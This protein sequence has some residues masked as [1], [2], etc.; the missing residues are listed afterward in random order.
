[1]NGLGLGANIQ[2]K[3][4]EKRNKI[5]NLTLGVNRKV[6][7]YKIDQ[8]RD[9]SSLFSRSQALSWLKMDFSSINYKIE[10]YDVKW[11]NS[12]NLTYLDYLKYVYAVLADNYQNEYVFKNEFLNNWL[13]KELG[14]TNS[15][16]FSEFRLGN[17]IADLV[18]F[19]GCSKIFEIKTELDNDSRLTLQVENYAKVFNQIFLI[20]PESKI[21][22]YEKHDASVGII[23]YAPSS[24]NIFSV[25][26]N[27]KLNPDI[28]VSVLM[29]ILHTNEYKSI[30]KKHY[31]F[32]PQM[33]SFNQF[34]I[35]SELIFEIPKGNLNKLFID[36]MKKRDS[37]DALSDRY[38]KEFNQL[39]LALKMNR[40]SKREMIESL[41]TTIQI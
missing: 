31:G 7:K 34:K 37:S 9:Y 39:F 5:L 6:M 8:L 17:S 1:M 21:H 14:E 38:Y 20:I 15:Q 33:T 32:L 24:K 3:S 36:E 10:R 35:C 11:L 16:I 25:F 13:I 29:S 4:Q 26:R 28:E 23:T 30:V 22:L 12:Q 18:M 27:A 40:N 19:N 2:H 41:K